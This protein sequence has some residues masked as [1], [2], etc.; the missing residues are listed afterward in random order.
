MDHGSAYCQL[1]RNPGSLS[2]LAQS[3]VY[4][5]HSPL[6]LSP[7]QIWKW[8]DGGGGGEGRKKAAINLACSKCLNSGLESFLVCLVM[9]FEV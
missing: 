2:S 3:F 9:E 7:A 4:M 1:G 8:T 5:S 6:M